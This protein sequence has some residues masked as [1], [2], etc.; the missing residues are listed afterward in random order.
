MSLINFVLILLIILATSGLFSSLIVHLVGFFNNSERFNQISLTLLKFNPWVYVPAVI[1]LY[2][3]IADD[4][5]QDYQKIIFINCPEWMKYET[6]FVSYYVG[7]W[8]AIF[9]IKSTWRLIKRTASK[10]HR[11]NVELF[12]LNKII[13]SAI[14]LGFYSWALAIYYSALQVYR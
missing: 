1:I 2:Q 5:R 7:V 11:S 13:P 6:Y 14:N 8:V 9:T 10:T 4:P 12:N 3:L